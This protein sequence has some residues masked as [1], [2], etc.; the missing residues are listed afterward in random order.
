MVASELELADLKRVLR[1]ILL[2]LM[3]K[4]QNDRITSE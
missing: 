4:Y 1:L 2:R 3:K